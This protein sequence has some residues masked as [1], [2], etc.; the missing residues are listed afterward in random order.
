MSERNRR[1]IELFGTEGQRRI[2]DTTVGLVGYG[3][4]GSH[5]GQQLAYLGTRAFVIVEPDVT[6]ASNLNRLIGATP[7]DAVEN[8]PKI[9]IATRTIKAVNPAAEVRTTRADVGDLEAQ[10]LLRT[11]D[12]AF[13]AVDNDVARLALTELTAARNVHYI[14][15]ATDAGEHDNGTVW[16]GGRV[17]LSDAWGCLSC[18][19][20]LDQRAL[21]RASMSGDQRG[22][23]DR[24][25]GV[26]RAFLDESGPM[27]VSVNGV[28]AS[29]AVT[30]FIALVTEIRRPV[31]HLVYKG[32][33][34]IVA[35]NVD[36]MREG[37][38]YCHQRRESCS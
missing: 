32:D 35:R 33:L 15:T 37:C 11:V 8:T 24:I 16:F 7:Q 3:G 30:E 10:E 23:V 38:F 6:E 26:D 29:L 2:E 27:V 1:N 20:L 19:G 17:F 34:G 5:I 4:L 36:A 13:G 31:R 9:D 14:D 22:A 25:Y 28:T 12:V 21:A 18:A